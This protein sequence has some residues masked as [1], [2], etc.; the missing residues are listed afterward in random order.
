MKTRWNSSFDM[1]Y[2]TVEYEEVYKRFTA[3][4]ELGL[5]G[6]E[7]SRREWTILKQLRDVLKVRT[8]HLAAITHC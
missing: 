3:D 5:R 7:L 2:T 4:A 1:A 8:P 6:Y